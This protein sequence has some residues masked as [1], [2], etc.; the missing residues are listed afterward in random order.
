MFSEPVKGTI[1]DF[2]QF[3]N[4]LNFLGDDVLFKL[5]C[6][7]DHIVFCSNEGK[8]ILT[9]NGNPLT[10]LEFKKK[11]TSW[12]LSENKNITFTIIPVLE[13]CPE[14]TH[15]EKSRVTEIIEASKFLRAIPEK[16]HIRILDEKNIPDTIKNLAN[17]KISRNIL[18]NVSQISLIDL[19]L[20]E[21]K[22]VIEIKKVGLSDKL[23]PVIAVLSAIIVIISGILA[24]FPFK[25]KI[26]T[27][28]I[29]DSLTNK[30]VAKEITGKYIPE[31]LNAMDGYFN[32]IIYKQGKLISPGKD[33]KIGT[34]DDITLKL[35]K[36]KSS[37]FV[38]P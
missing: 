36:P 12:I 23:A 17:Q 10:E 3:L 14:G 27:L 19:C 1:T 4:L 30:I 13:N 11:L 37:I 21:N 38:I 31:K 33:R 35:P 20:L 7:N 16:L 24:I 15:I 9:S 2:E 29:M 18:I 8:V 32:H 25:D 5:N 28:T 22:G 26:L 6:D 34:P